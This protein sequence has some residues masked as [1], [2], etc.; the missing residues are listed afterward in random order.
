MP[1]KSSESF[2]KHFNI[3]ATVLLVIIVAA[4]TTVGL[5]VLS[6]ASQSFVKISQNVLKKQFYCLGLAS[7]AFGMS[8]F[9]DLNRL[10]KYTHL[11][12]FG[13][14]ILLVVVLIPGIGIKVNGAR[15]W[16]N[17]GV[18]R[19][20]VSDCAKIGL[21]FCLAHY[22]ALNR[23]Y[24][25]EW[26]R[27]FMIP[28]SI[29]LSITGIILLQPDFG[30]AFLCAT[31]GFSLLF[32][33]GVPLYYIL[34]TFLTGSSLFGII[35]YFNPNRLKRITSFLDLE[36]NRSDGSYQLWQSI[37]G[38]AAGGLRGMGLGHGRQ[39]LSFLPEAHTDFILP[40]I[41]EELGMI[42]TLLV[43]LAFLVFFLIS[44]YKVYQIGDLYH[45]CVGAGSL[46]FITYQAIINIGV[47]TGLLP[48]KGLALP[49]ISYGG[50]NLIVMYTLAGILINCIRTRDHLP[51]FRGTL[52]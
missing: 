45:F 13:T 51:T 35:I 44:A 12:A 10:R 9:G 20:Q 32:L 2:F 3:S 22:I 15:R 43:V 39:Q 4:L 17:L 26:T 46:L 34:P 6:S 28:V 24:L 47:V 49:F 11:I 21:V 7:I 37:L 18:T 5:I 40:I 50:S 14:G 19:M 33:V 27:G 36:G 41:G 52:V 31:V 38:F 29:I 8:V 48:T 30:T 16:L 23:R 1:V 42:F 25:K